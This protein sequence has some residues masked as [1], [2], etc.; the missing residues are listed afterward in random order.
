MPIT[1]CQSSRHLKMFCSTNS[2]KPEDIE[3]T[4]INTKEM[5]HEVLFLVSY[6]SYQSSIQMD[7]QPGKV[8]NC[9]L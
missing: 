9:Q 8:G 3:F 1:T 7:Y 4:L 5:I 2:P 6:S